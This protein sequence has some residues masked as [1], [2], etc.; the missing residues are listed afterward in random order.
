MTP[1]VCSGV[2]ALEFVGY[3]ISSEGTRPLESKVKAIVDFSQQ[4][5]L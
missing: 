3:A 4:T 5:F 1:K 2:P